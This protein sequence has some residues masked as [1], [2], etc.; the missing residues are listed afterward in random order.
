VSRKFLSSTGLLLASIACAEPAAARLRDKVVPPT[1]NPFNLVELDP[2]AAYGLGVV[3]CM[4]VKPML[5]SAIKGRELTLK[6]AHEAVAGC[7]LPIVGGWL[8]RSYF[9]E[10]WN[11]L[12]TRR[13]ERDMGIGAYS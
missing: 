13:W 10:S 12:P 2:L 1:G 3:F 11:K 4:A 7:I 6:E 9:P 8:V 5:S